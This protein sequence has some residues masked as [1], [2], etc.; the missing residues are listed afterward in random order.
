MSDIV[1]AL[2]ESGI[3]IAIY[4]PDSVFAQTIQDV[5]ASEQIVT[6]SCGREDVG[7]A[8][9][10][11][12][13]LT[14]HLAVV[15]MEGSGI[16]YSGLILTRAQLQRTP[17]LVMASHTSGIGEPFDYHGATCLV[18]EGVLSGLRIPAHRLDNRGEVAS[19]IRRAVQT[20]RGRKTIMALYFPPYILLEGTS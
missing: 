20:I 4:V 5:E 13:F 19:S 2:T 9:A 18:G 7:I 14:G 3:D 17:M 8:M 10:A 11:G 16:G 6:Y 15:M 12:A 1:D